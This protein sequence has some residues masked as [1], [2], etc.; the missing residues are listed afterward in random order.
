M[1]LTPFLSSVFDGHYRGIA[2]MVYYYFFAYK[3]FIVSV[4]F[5][6]LDYIFFEL[7]QLYTAGVV[8]FIAKPVEAHAHQAIYFDCKSPSKVRGEALL[9]EL[10]Y[11]CCNCDRNVYI[12]ICVCFS[13]NS[14]SFCS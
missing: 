3:C 13:N 14:E 6:L 4:N 10:C 5:L 12:C 7:F 1:F 2:K 9:L 8:A 11:C